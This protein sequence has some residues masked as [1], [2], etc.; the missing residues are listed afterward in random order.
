MKRQKLLLTNLFT[1]CALAMLP[2]AA[3]AQD[4]VASVATFDE[5]TLPA[6]S[7]WFGDGEPA[8][9]YAGEIYDFYSGRYMFTGMKHSS[10]WWNGYALSNETATEYTDLSHQFRSAA[11]GA[12]S[13]ANYAVYYYDS[14]DVVSRIYNV[15]DEAGAPISGMYVTNAAYALNSILNGDDYGSTPFATGDYFKLIVKGYD[16][17]DEETGTVEFYLADYRSENEAE[18]YAL[19][20]WEWCDLSSLGAVSSIHIT[21]ETSQSNTWGALTPLYVCIDDFNGEHTNTGVS[22]NTIKADT[23]ISAAG[24]SV[25]ISTQAAGYTVEVYT[26]GGALAASRKGCS[27]TMSLD[28]GELPSGVYIV[29]ANGTAQRVAIR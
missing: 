8:D 6:E 23:R 13:G 26:T 9:M 28:L 7:N 20:T 29:R 21:F 18:H 22:V 4:E 3:M 17:N 15:Y 12:H 14:W 5:T 1:V 2:A 24:K 25:N 19:T 11:G 10:S 16:I 27:G